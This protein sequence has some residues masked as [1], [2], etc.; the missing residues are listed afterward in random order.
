MHIQANILTNNFVNDI[1]HAHVLSQMAGV[2]Q[3]QIHNENGDKADK[4]VV[5]VDDDELPKSG[6]KKKILLGVGAL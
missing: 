3:P 1:L 4:E 2:S 5:V 6:G